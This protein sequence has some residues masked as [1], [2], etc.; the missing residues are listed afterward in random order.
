MRAPEFSYL[1]DVH[2]QAGAMRFLPD[3]L[4]HLSIRRPLLITDPGLAPLADRFGISHAAMFDGVQTNPTEASVMAA[5]DLYVREK[6]DGVI[7]FGGGSPMDLAK[8]AA[9]IATHDG[10]LEQYS[11][12]S[13]GSKRITADLPPLIAIPTTAGS[14]SEVGRAALI[15]LDCGKKLGFISPRLLPRAVLC[16]P[17]LTI[18]MPAALT[19]GTGM[20]AIS[21]CVE[22]FCS[23]RWNPVADA[24][25]IDG[26][27]RG[28]QN[29]PLA[30]ADGSNLA[31]RSEMM[32][33]SIEGGLAFQKGLGAVHSL[34]HPLG[35]LTSRRLH[36]GTLNAIFL[37]HVLRFNLESS[38]DKLAVV[39]GILGVEDANS[40]PSAFERFNRSI[41]LPS[42]LKDLG[43]LDED[44]E[45]LVEAAFNDHCTATNPRQLSR[46]DLH[47]L[48]LAALSGSILEEK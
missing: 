32:L 39:A 19:A 45:P 4:E 14:G 40:L 38:R 11:F 20:D 13:G 48:Y 41:G 5:R 21:H 35:A 18:S 2:F 7:A 24:L 9:L 22:T 26:L 23:P 47:Q 25:A 42:S 30:V 43:V 8:C 15:T 6:C 33:C 27:K 37:P 31:A 10:P 17:E 36:H 3:L 44:L 34:S 28:W 1:T 29:L 16:D 12:S 46:A